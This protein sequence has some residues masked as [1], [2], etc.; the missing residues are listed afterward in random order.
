MRRIDL[1][2]IRTYEDLYPTIES[3]ALVSGSAPDWI[4]RDWDRA[5]HLNF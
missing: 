3:G 1:T 2:T 4:K 5:T